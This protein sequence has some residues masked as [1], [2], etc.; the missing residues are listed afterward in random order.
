M[1]YDFSKWRARAHYVG[2]LMTNPKGKSNMQKYKEAVTSQAEAI[3]TYNN[4]TEK[5][6]SAKAKA[7]EK[8]EKLQSVIDLLSNVK[9]VPH[10]S[11]TCISKLNEIYTTLDTGRTKK[12]ESKY[13]SKGLHVEE[14]SITSYS[15]F[16]GKMF[17]KNEERRFN[18][19]VEGE[20]DIYNEAENET[21]DTKS[22]WD[23]FSFD[24]N[25]FKSLNP[26]YYW[27]GQCYMWLWNTKKHKVV[28]SL[29]DTP[30]FLVKK[31][32]DWEKSN[33]M[34]TAEEWEEAKLQIISR[35]YY[36]D[37]SNNKE[38]WLHRYG[39]MFS[40]PLERKIQIYEIERDDN[41]IE[42]MKERIKICREYLCNIT[43]I[44]NDTQDEMD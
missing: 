13:L 18:D 14:D 4:C 7:A 22:S 30:D 2:L 10:L 17:T 21:A 19:F 34:G 15:L 39:N 27:Q 5:Q 9:D 36:S 43:N 3:E 38:H 32:L 33:F 28:Y 6:I 24:A 37:Y 41:S 20:C 35:N 1:P 40:L 23:V 31:E 29:Q 25:R 26:I 12:I 44:K 8:I 11:T 16:C 42:A